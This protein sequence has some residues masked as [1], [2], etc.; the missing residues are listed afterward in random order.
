[1]K[2]LVRDKLVNKLVYTEFGFEVA[3]QVDEKEVGMH[4]R[5]IELLVNLQLI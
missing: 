1:V 4:T 2:N 3:E 5:N